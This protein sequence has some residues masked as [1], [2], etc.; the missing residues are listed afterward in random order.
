MSNPNIV[1]GEEM[2][3]LNLRRGKWGWDYTDLYF[4][5]K[6]NVKIDGWP[7]IVVEI[8]FYN[9]DGFISKSES[10]GSVS[11]G[12]LSPVWVLYD[13]DEPWSKAELIGNRP[14]TGCGVFFFQ[15][16]PQGND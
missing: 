6:S 12:E 13:R 8:K 10:T 14:C 5:I 3:I 16:I 1:Q 11:P 15:D 9:P 7:G 2:E 4:D